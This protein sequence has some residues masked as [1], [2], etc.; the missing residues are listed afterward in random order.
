ME[1]NKTMGSVCAGKLQ[2]WF[3]EKTLEDVS[4]TD[5]DRYCREGLMEA[6]ASE[7]LNQRMVAKLKQFQQ[8]TDLDGMKIELYNDHDLETCHYTRMGD[9]IHFHHL[10]LPRIRLLA[11]M[12]NCLLPQESSTIASN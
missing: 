1:F 11:H 12:V 8:R 6:E 4:Q 2:Y 10:Q 7:R 9:G 3:E 5:I